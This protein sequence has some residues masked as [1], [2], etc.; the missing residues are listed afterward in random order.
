MKKLLAILLA[1]SLLALCAC[2]A[3]PAQTTE[4]KPETEPAQTADT[5]TPAEETEAGAETGSEETSSQ[6]PSDETPE[7]GAKRV[8]PMPEAIDVN[9]LTDAMVAAS[10]DESA[11]EEKDGKTWLNLEVYDYDLYDMVDIAQLAVGDT[12][13]AGGK[14]LRVESVEDDG[15]FKL[16]NGGL[17][18]GGVTL[19]TNENG[20]YYE[21]G[22]DDAKCYRELGSVT[23]ELADDCTVTDASD[24]AQ[25]EK[26]FSVSE[27][28]Q[29]C[30]DAVGISAAN[31]V[32][33]VSG[34]KIVA[35]ARTYTP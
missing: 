29:L 20:V 31:T 15:G 32:V 9:T 2:A 27:L 11:I 8:E 19:A 34:G 4:T 14:D 25:P 30:T 13:V 6:E 26:S 21:V 16:I 18:S 35:I 23:L 33:T 12:F 5:Q 28:A 24:P 10:F 3:K 17:E 22:M 7:D 1:L